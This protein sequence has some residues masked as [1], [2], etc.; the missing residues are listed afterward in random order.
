MS[1][2][3]F[4]DFYPFYLSQHSTRMCRRLHFIGAVGAIVVV[5]LALT[6][7]SPWWLL[8]APVIGYGCAWGGHF[9]FEKNRPATFGHPWYSLAGDGL[10]FWQMLSGR[11]SF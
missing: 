5:V 7:I 1:F 2:A 4:A 9:A 8:L 11:L 10:M 6:V 3:S